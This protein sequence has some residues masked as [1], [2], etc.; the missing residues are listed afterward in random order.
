MAEP[1]KPTRRYRGISPQARVE[2]RRTRLIQAGFEVF[3]D[4]GV[5]Q[6]TVKQICSAAG[7][8][9]RYFYESFKNQPE[10][11]V[12]VYE[13]GIEEI[14]GNILKA[15]EGAAPRPLPLTH[16]AMTAFFETLKAQPR[17]ARVLLVEVYG[18]TEDLQ[19]L[20][21]RG[22]SDFASIARGLI[23]RHALL[24]DEPELDPDLLSTAVIGAAIHL[25]LRWYLEG[26]KQ[27]VPTMVAH[28]SALLRAVAP[29]QG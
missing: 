29:P 28:G 4:I 22:V 14:Q 7:L 26:F 23:D 2:Q 18:S 20:Y 17:L 16:A 8:T 19:R 9:E 24:Q 25:A 6:A 21:T 15:L 10:L 1:G 27:S 5:A 12:A 13:A 3:G 11:F